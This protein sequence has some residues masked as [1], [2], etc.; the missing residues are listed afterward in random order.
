MNKIDFRKTLAEQF[1]SIDFSSFQCGDIFVIKNNRHNTYTTASIDC[2]WH[3]IAIA[4]CKNYD[5]LINVNCEIVYEPIHHSC[6]RSDVFIKRHVKGYEVY[7]EE[8]V[9]APGKDFHWE[10][11]SMGII[12]ETFIQHE[13]IEIY[14]SRVIWSSYGNQYEQG[15]LICFND[16]FYEYST[17]KY[18]F[19]IPSTLKFYKKGTNYFIEDINGYVFDEND[20][21]YN[22]RDMQYDRDIIV[23]VTGYKIVSYLILPIVKDEN[24]RHF[25][26]TDYKKEI[27]EYRNIFA[28]YILPKHNNYG[29]ADFLFS[30][31][32]NEINNY[33]T[34]DF[35]LFEKFP[36]LKD[37][38]AKGLELHSEIY[39]KYK[40]DWV[41]HIHEKN[42]TLVIRFVDSGYVIC[43]YS[44]LP[45]NRGFTKFYIF[46]HNGNIYSI[47][48]YDWIDIIHCR[49][50]CLIF[51][52][53]NE[54]GIISGK[55]EKIIYK[56]LINNRSLFF[57]STASHNNSG[58]SLYSILMEDCC[59]HF[60]A[61]ME[62]VSVLNI[63]DYSNGDWIG[64]LYEPI[65]NKLEK[66]II[67]EPLALRP[68]IDKYLYML[69]NNQIV[70]K[71]ETIKNIGYYHFYFKSLVPQ[72]SATSFEIASQT[73]IDETMKNIQEKCK[74]A[75]Q[76]IRKITKLEHI[77]TANERY[78]LFEYRPFGKIDSHGNITYE[79]GDPQD[80]K[81]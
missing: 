33:I 13:A 60:N 24:I 23:K 45:N 59:Y 49:V 65:Y 57:G 3:G 74:E 5:C 2:F 71:N 81:L 18:K 25:I 15:K 39:E 20:F 37:I 11:R 34:S 63:R 27:I 30:R 54:Y 52:R 68:V 7:G 28:R 9:A 42:R 26:E 4:H 21:D 58:K 69:P 53:D 8:D 19:T 14:K 43:C 70:D 62:E 31:D 80:I 41:A 48:G 72:V 76:Y 17:G 55:Q 38:F 16:I 73:S 29:F 35:N 47:K 66:Q 64:Y 51:K 78:Y 50:N 10:E 75:N 56:D 1:R 61:E 67:D 79:F 12:D 77:S 6:R 22:I 36:Q 40:L 44:N 32:S 46:D